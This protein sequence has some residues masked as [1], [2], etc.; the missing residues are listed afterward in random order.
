MET[1]SKKTQSMATAKYKQ[2]QPIIQKN[3]SMNIL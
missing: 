1:Y 2:K 3:Q